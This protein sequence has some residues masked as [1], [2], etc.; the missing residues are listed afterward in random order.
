MPSS[1]FGGD[2]FVL[3]VVVGGG[4]G[5]NAFQVGPSRAPPLHGPQE[6][7]LARAQ[8][9]SATILGLRRWAGSHL[10]HEDSPAEADLDGKMDQSRRKQVVLRHVLPASARR[11]SGGETNGGLLCRTPVVSR[12]IRFAVVLPFPPLSTLLHF[13]SGNFGDA[14]DEGK[15][16]SN[17][18]ALL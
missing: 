15:N 4:C 6:L 2:G 9:G 11:W 7:G 3:L 18:L 13:Y 14:D 12:L 5:L 16:S 8:G 1:T 10:P 17:F